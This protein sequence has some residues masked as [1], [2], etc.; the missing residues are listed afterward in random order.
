VVQERQRVFT[1]SQGGKPW[2]YLLVPHDAV[3]HNATVSAL[4][5]VDIR[6]R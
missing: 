6:S 2:K 3:A 4:A 5:G 1:G